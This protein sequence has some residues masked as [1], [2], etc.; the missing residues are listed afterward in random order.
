MTTMSAARWHGEKIGFKLDRVERPKPRATDVLIRVKACGVIPNLKNVLLHFQKWHPYLVLPPFPAIY[1]L[2]ASGEVAEVGSQVHSIGVGDRVYVNPGV[3]CGSCLAC[4]TGVP[5]SCDAFTFLGYFGFGE[6]SRQVYADYPYAG[7]G[8]YMTAPAH[9]LVRLPAAVSFEE[10]A[11]FGYLGTAYAG[12][13]KGGARAGKTVLVS[14][15]TGTLGLGGVL[16]AL[17]MGCTKVFAMARNRE[18]LDRVRALDPRRIE[19]VYADEGSISGRVRNATD[20][21]GV[22]VFLDAIGPGAPASVSME[23]LASLRRGG[24]MA[25]VGQV[26]EP[27]PIDM[28]KLLCSANNI[29]G[30][31]W[32]N[33]AEG[34]DMATMRAAGTLDLSVLEHQRF[35]PTQI[36]AALEAIEHRRGGFTNV[37]IVPG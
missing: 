35:A 22:D 7:F 21:L 6:G 13:L 4:R 24:T 33:I 31:L 14:G 36:D 27:L 26:S 5:T 12:L 28:H 2:D 37:V 11:R 16:F 29:V 18:L 10:G 9:S 23:G 1:G 15:A 17:A 30:S 34:Q 20:G 19:V 32:F 8:E 3:G 25:V